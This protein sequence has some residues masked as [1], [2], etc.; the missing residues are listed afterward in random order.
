MRKQQVKSFIAMLVCC[1][2]VIA[3]TTACGGSDNA[4]VKGGMISAKPL[5]V[6]QL[7]EGFNAQYL[8]NTSKIKQY[9]GKIDVCLDFEGTQG[10]WQALAN[11]YQRLQ[12]KSVVVNINT[13]Y[14]GRF[15]RALRTE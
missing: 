11:E 7:G 6:E 12:G 9:S 3:L 4:G 2:T 8:P 5:Q 15:T 13:N 1:S 10:G 14:S